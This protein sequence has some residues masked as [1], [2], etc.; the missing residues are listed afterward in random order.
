MRKQNKEDEQVLEELNS[1]H[2]RLQAKCQLVQT[3]YIERIK[4]YLFLP[5]NKQR[6]NPA[7]GLY[8]RIMTLVE[9]TDSLRSV[10]T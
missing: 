7:G 8:G 5:Y 1:G 3:S 6:I 9:C 4:L 10:C 2:S